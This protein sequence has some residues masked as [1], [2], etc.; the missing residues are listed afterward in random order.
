M[1]RQG[2][3]SHRGDGPE[4]VV[5]ARPHVLIIDDNLDDCR[6]MKREL[7]GEVERLFVAHSGQD[8][9]RL[10]EAHR[11]DCILLDYCLPD[12][13]GL[14]VLAALKRPDAASADIPVVMLTGAGSEEV[15]VQALQQG[16]SDYVCKGVKISPTSLARAI[17]NAIEAASLRRRALDAEEDL[18]FFA[19]RAAHDLKS[20]IR[21]IRSG[22]RRI[23]DAVGCRDGF[24]EE[25]RLL[26]VVVEELQRIEQTCRRAD[27]LIDALLTFSRVSVNDRG[28]CDTDA[29]CE[30]E[31]VLANIIE[32]RCQT[33]HDQQQCTITVLG[34]LPPVRG[35]SS[36]VG[37]V[38]DNVISNALKYQPKD[39][40]HTAR[41]TI[42]CED[43]VRD[44]TLRANA[45]CVTLAIRDNGIGIEPGQ[46]D[47]I[48][49]PF[50]RLHNRTTYPG[51]GL[52]LATCVRVMERLGGSIKV[53]SAGTGRGATVYLTF[54][55]AVDR[56]EPE[57]DVEIVGR[58][59]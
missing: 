26:G 52:G 53:Q 5:T 59:V 28:A 17:H 9:L 37:I 22:T 10:A 40:G 47:A 24:A 55:Q 3:A 46:L 54:K 51:S 32:S 34:E 31:H 27:A 7:A 35:S 11:P 48:L 12:R 36:L 39:C 13:D 15:A 8:G 58:S 50:E 23:Q 43:Q 33:G 20:P 4:R 45:R 14:D 56:V 42:C 16:A 18:R 25:G 29:T 19:S 30:L 57:S 21:V 38:L 2:T 6:V 49:Q 41:I 44:K 1:I